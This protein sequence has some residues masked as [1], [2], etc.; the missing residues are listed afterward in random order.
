MGGSNFK[1][2]I[3]PLTGLISMRNVLLSMFQVRIAMAIRKTRE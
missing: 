2:T 1:Y 3:S